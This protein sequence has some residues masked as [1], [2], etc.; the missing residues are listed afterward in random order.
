[1]SDTPARL[2]AR[3]DRREADRQVAARALEDADRVEFWA[4][5]CR[6]A[7]GRAGEPPDRCA[8][9]EQAANQLRE[10]AANASQA[11]RH[12]RVKARGH[13]DDDDPGQEGEARR[14]RTRG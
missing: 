4:R 14:T 7:L 5:S 2:A 11:S 1:V 12:R 6:S 9:L 3:C 13:D 8:V 10:V